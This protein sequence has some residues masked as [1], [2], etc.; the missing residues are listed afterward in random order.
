[1]LSA[2]VA[3]TIVVQHVSS[4]RG[5]CVSI[6]PSSSPALLPQLHRSDSADA[7][8]SDPAHELDEDI[9]SLGCSDNVSMKA[10]GSAGV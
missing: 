4:S 5:P 3:K 6:E 7:I 2:R 8:F 1:M 10:L 9:L